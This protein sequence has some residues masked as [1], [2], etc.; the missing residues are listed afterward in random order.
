ME[1]EDFNEEMLADKPLL[2]S[3]PVISSKP[4][5]EEAL[6]VCSIIILLYC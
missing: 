6:V 1:A 2:A 3:L 4:T 5:L